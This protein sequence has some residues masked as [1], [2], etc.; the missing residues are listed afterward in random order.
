MSLS[1][2]KIDIEK[3]VVGAFYSVGAAAKLALLFSLVRIIEKVAIVSSVSLLNL[4]LS[5][6]LYYLIIGGL[7]TFIA[8]V[9]IG[10]PL[11]IVLIK[12]GLDDS[13]LVAF[14]SAIFLVLACI[15]LE[16]KQTYVLVLMIYSFF[17]SRAFINGYKKV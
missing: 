14:I 3:L 1:S 10:F 9:V 13:E 5:S 16:I 2:S 7:I 11:A 6:L 8:S 4:S 17:C 15:C 12:C